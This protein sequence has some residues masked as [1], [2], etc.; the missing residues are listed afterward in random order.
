MSE[1]DDL[2]D[3]VRGLLDERASSEA[4]RA[5]VATPAGFDPALFATVAE[6]GLTGLL[7]PEE[8]GGSGGEPADMAVV[9]HELGRR[10][11]PLPFLQSAVLAPTAL[12]AAPGSVADELLPAIVE[13][14][15]RVAVVL[16]GPQGAVGP[17]TWAVDWTDNGAGGGRIDGVV[18]EVMD[19]PS[20]DELIVVARSADGPVVAVLPFSAVRVES[21]TALDLT[22]RLGTATFDG[23]EVPADRVLAR[24]PQAEQLVAVVLRAAAW[25]L[26]CDAVGLAERTMEQTAAYARDRHQ[27]GRPIG[28]FQAV[29]HACATMSVTVECGRAAVDT[30]TRLLTAAVTR[31]ADVATSTAKQFA[32]DGAVEVCGS[33]VQVHGG[34]GFTWEHDAH[35]WLKRALLDRALF[36][37]SAWH[38]RRVADA[39]LPVP[40]G[41]AG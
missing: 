26:A 39:V 21:V 4:L 23:A 14:Q 27:F 17:Q 40:A 6:L 5:A 19:L 29:K 9:L 33:A 1:R 34:I 30:A 15:V 24:G 2:R 32:G 22:R 41:V 36:G 25:G 7:V 31:E 35:I 12:L 8:R 13:G 20:A 3:M 10:A 28:S 18:G 37:S 11:T 38:R 16:G